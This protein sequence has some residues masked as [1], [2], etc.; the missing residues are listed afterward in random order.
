MKKY[1]ALLRGINV[2]GQK[3]I[4]M[5]ELRELLSGVKGMD[6]VA[7]YIQSGNIVFTSKE[8]QGELQGKIIL[9]IEEHYGY[10]VGVFVY[11]QSEWETIV[12]EN[13]FLQDDAVDA[14][15]C[16][17]SCLDSVPEQQLVDTLKE[18][19]YLPDEFRVIGKRIYVHC[20]NGYGRTKLHNNFFEKKLKV[21]A[22]TRNWR[23]TMKLLGMME[24]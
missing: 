12:S 15:K 16:H 5:A 11:S 23:T 4:K 22:T 10:K 14:T 18:S 21:S 19:E 9:A 13:P 20:P 17:L 7:T 3:K 6:D 8:E 2:S 24:G 1:I